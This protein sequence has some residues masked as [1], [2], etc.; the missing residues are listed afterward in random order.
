MLQIYFASSV[1]S[2]SHHCPAAGHSG[3][4]SLPLGAISNEQ[5]NSESGMQRRAKQ[6]RW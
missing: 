3:S 4:A 2:G 1:T 5:V 6:A